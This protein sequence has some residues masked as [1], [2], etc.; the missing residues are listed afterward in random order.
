MV[1]SCCA[2]PTG[3]A[4]LGLA[5]VMAACAPDYVYIQDGKSERAVRQDYIGCAEQQFKG[6]N[7]TTLCMESRGYRT[8]KIDEAARAPEHSSAGQHAIVR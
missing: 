6:S 2:V 5:F 8:L 1:E 4:V 7:D 3:F